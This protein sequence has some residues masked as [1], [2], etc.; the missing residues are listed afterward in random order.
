[1]KQSL[2]D[3]ATDRSCPATDPSIISSEPRLLA[4]LAFRTSTHFSRRTSHEHALSVRAKSKAGG[5]LNLLMTRKFKRSRDVGSAQM[6]LVCI[7]T[8]NQYLTTRERKKQEQRDRERD[9]GDN[10]IGSLFVINRATNTH[11]KLDINAATSLFFSGFNRD[12]RIHD[13][14][15]LHER[16]EEKP[17]CFRHDEKKPTRFLFKR[18]NCVLLLLMSTNSMTKGGGGERKR[19]ENEKTR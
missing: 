8:I 11:Y 3:G 17:P 13:P 6:V 12:N 9:R 19:K 4:P 1:L 16:E 14:E 7:A 18:S 10:Q 5:K 15:L 2:V